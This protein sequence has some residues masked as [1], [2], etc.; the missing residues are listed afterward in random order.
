MA[1]GIGE[2]VGGTSAEHQARDYVASVFRELRYRVALQPFAVPDKYLASLVVGGETWKA[3]ASRFGAVDVSVEGPVLDL[4]DGSVLPPDLTGVVVLLVDVA[5]GFGP[6][7]EAVRRGAAAVLLGRIT[8]PGRSGAFSPVLTEV[9]PVPVVGLAQVHV[10]RLRAAGVV[11][12]V[13]GTRVLTGLT[14]YNVIAERPATGRGDKVVMVTAHYDSVPGS[15]G[16]NDDGSGTALVLELAR[17]LRYL[18]VARGLRF[19]L[20]GSEEQGLLGSRHYVSQLPA[21][22]LGR[23]AGVFQNDMVAT[24]HVG[25]SAYWLL[26]VDGGANVTTTAVAEAAS[27][28]GYRGQVRGPVARGSSDH[29]PFHE[30]GV[31][32]ANFSWRGEAGPGALEPLYH[33]PEDTIALNVSQ[34]RLQISL[35][36]IGSAVY[37]VATGRG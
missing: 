35:E 18:P 23:V 16:A 8:S 4:G 28:L 19:A 24:S 33:T 9:V 21:V 32:A 11:S 2:R 31:A 5:A 29:V 6:V 17:V 10:E 12:V 15:P 1:E 34:A 27:R 13:V 26:S 7:F 30:K 37:R 14:S 25:S 36:L 20:W 22:E 3:A